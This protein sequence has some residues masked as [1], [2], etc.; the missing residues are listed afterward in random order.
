MQLVVSLLRNFFRKQRENL[1]VFLQLVL[2][3]TRHSLEGIVA[4]TSGTK[5]LLKYGTFYC[6]ILLVDCVV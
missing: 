6:F 1:R 4:L 5:E 3:L 2:F